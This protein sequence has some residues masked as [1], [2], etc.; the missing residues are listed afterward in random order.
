MRVI[1]GANANVVYPAAVQA[2][3]AGRQTASRV[4]D[5]LELHPVTLVIDNPRRRLVTSFGRPVNVAFALAE[6]LWILG[7]RNDV[8]M[9]KS[10]NGTIDNYSDDGFT[11]N[12]AYGHR[13]RFDYGHD[14]IADVIA[15]LRA[16]P[17][18]RQASLVLSLP[19]RDRAFRPQPSHNGGNEDFVQVRHE[20]KDRACNVYAHLMIRDGALNWLQIVRSND[21]VW[22][23]PYN[24]MQWMHLQ[25]FIAAAVGVEVGTY[26]HV[27]DSLH[28]YDYHWDAGQAIEQFDLY[29][30]LGDD[31]DPIRGDTTNLPTIILL[32]SHEAAL[33]T[34][35]EPWAVP[36]PP[37]SAVGYYWHYV[38]AVLQSYHCYRLGNDDKAL[39]S[40]WLCDD[41]I[42][43]LAQLRHY[44]YWRWYKPEYQALWN[45]ALEAFGLKDAQGRLSSASRERI[46]DWL[47]AAHNTPA[48][49]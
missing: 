23:T 14:Q 20:T 24:F 48:T 36:A 12:A 4:S 34:S 39:D 9:L 25:E 49:A 27:A 21:V 42:L 33:R 18:T 5:T 38:Y 8:D 35:E 10:Y 28:M 29:D 41:D 26:T 22:G 16:E 6:V 47:T 31:H 32:L 1:Q 17:N 43:A 3:M 15:L 13:L 37:S 46:I 40:L 45:R 2:V 11:F 7:G 30:V 44:Y 19:S